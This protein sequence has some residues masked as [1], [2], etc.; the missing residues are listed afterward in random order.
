MHIGKR[1]AP[2]IAEARARTLMTTFGTKIETTGTDALLDE[3]KW[4]AGHV[5]YARG[6]V[7]AL[8]PEELVWGTTQRKVTDSLDKDDVDAGFPKVS[9]STE[10]AE[11]NVW[12]KI[13][14][15]ER[16]HLVKVCSEAIRCGIEE[17]RIRLAEDAGGE[18]TDLIRT[19]LAALNLT[20]EQQALIPEVIPRVLKAAALAARAL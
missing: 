15:A 19:V 6:Q 2:V 8:A 17:R 13:Y 16:A 1:A 4:T 5:A 10:G 9:E 11:L 18:L 12:L 3:I 20:P 7:Q 14:Q